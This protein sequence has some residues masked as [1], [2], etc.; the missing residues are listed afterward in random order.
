MADKVLPALWDATRQGELPVVS[1]AVSCTEGLRHMIGTGDEPY[2]RLRVVDAVEFTATTLMP[3][4]T[5]T[6]KAD[7][8]ALHPTCSATRLGIDTHLYSVAAAVSGNVVVPDEWNCCGFAGDR[9]LLH[10][11][12]TA[13]AT[14]RQAAELTSNAEQSGGHDAHVSCN[15]TC[16]LGM[17]RATGHTYEHLI[18]LVERATR[19]RPQ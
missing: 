18:E 11:E 6:A 17:T 5:V 14:A 10:P 15:R 9:G 2:R 3:L 7:S 19:P 13:S 1:D 12:L 8:V 4:L 16:E